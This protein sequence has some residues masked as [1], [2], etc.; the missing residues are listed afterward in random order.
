V[1][2]RHVARIQKLR[3][4]YDSMGNRVPPPPQ[5]L[6]ESKERAKKRGRKKG[7][8]ADLEQ[9][10]ENIVAV[11]IISLVQFSLFFNLLKNIFPSFLFYGK[12]VVL[13]FYDLL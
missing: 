11:K 9:N 7:G 1:A 3:G 12:M 2:Q 8:G 6:A 10:G 4:T 13:R 5:V